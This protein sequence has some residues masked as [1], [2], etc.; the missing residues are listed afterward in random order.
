MYAVTHEKA[1]NSVVNEAQD[2]FL[3]G[4]NEERS[5]RCGLAAAARVAEPR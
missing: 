2:V 5:T 1:L 3:N 4:E